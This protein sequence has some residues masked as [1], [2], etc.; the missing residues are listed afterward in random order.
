MLAPRGQGIQFPGFLGP[1]RPR[2]HK[3][4]TPAHSRRPT[5]SGSPRLAVPVN[6]SAKLPRALLQARGS[7]WEGSLC[8]AGKEITGSE[9]P[10]A[11][12]AAS[13]SRAPGSRA[14]SRARRAEDWGLDSCTTH[15]LFF[16]AID[17][18]V[19]PPL[20]AAYWQR[21][22]NDVLCAA[23]VSPALASFLLLIGNWMCS[24][25]PDRFIFFFFTM[26]KP[27]FKT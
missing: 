24:V 26:Q 9:C 8:S 25:L 3:A 21:L 16:W 18:P 10:W 15:C 22:K 27:Y 19:A 13:T 4:R 7:W 6:W 17:P 5:P 20:A 11:K 14:H 12:K 2:L 23:W 1:P